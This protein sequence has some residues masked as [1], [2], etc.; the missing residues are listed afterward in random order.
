MQWLPH[1]Y[2]DMVHLLLKPRAEAAKE[3][4]SIGLQ[5]RSPVVTGSMNKVPWG[6]STSAVSSLDEW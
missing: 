5:P 6:L 2:D 4:T 3:N 1:G